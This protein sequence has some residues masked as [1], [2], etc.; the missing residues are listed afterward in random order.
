MCNLHESSKGEN[1][2]IPL[3]T[4]VGFTMVK[5]TPTFDKAI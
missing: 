1:A 5:H 4:Y 3:T 2:A